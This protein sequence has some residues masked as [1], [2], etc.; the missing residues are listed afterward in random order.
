MRSVSTRS[1]HPLLSSNIAQ[2]MVE[3]EVLADTTSFNFLSNSS[4]DIK[5]LIDRD[6]AIYSLSVVDRE[7]YFINLEHHM[8]G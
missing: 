3:A 8:M 4:N 2:W 6:I 5:F 1:M 7:I